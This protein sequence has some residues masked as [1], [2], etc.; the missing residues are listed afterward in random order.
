M[1]TTTSLLI[2]YTTET[3]IKTTKQKAVPYVS[4]EATDEQLLAFAN[5]VFELT[6]NT[7]KSV[8]KITRKELE[9]E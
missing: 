8:V 7:V 2:N 1:A 9:A 5:S 4:D 6:T 3:D